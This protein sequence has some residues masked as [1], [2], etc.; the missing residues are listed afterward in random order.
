[1]KLRLHAVLLIANALFTAAVAAAPSG[2]LLAGIARIDITPSQPV[3]L[4]GYASRKELSEGVH[5]HIYARAIALEQEGQRLT[6]VSVE[7]CGFYNSTADPLRK[8]VLAATGLKP[9]ELFMCATHTHS[10]PALGLDLAK[11]HSNNVA[12][13]QLLERKLVDVVQ[14]ALHRLGPIEVGF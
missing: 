7:N 11:S 2:G 12:Y 6:F 4:A 1:M 9:S 5:D 10:A 14:Q 3:M 13:T 8:A